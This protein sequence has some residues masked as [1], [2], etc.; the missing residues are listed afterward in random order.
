MVCVQDPNFTKQYTFELFLASS[1]AN[2]AQEY[3]LPVC[4]ALVTFV[5]ALVMNFK[6][7][8]GKQLEEHICFEYIRGNHPRENEHRYEKTLVSLRNHLH[9][10]VSPHQC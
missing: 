10:V 8:S 6:A 7:L 2:S 9:M 3:L 5:C 4:L 1:A